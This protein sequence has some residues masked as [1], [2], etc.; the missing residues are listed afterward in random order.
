MNHIVSNVLG[1]I[2]TTFSE[3]YFAT[4][5]S[6]VRVP[7][8]VKTFTLLEAMK[9][10]CK[11]KPNSLTKKAARYDT[12]NKLMFTYVFLD[13]NHGAVTTQTTQPMRNC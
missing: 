10:V 13:P 8:K 5:H 7:G 6:H 2:L 3:I 1:K 9:F 11:K 4:S 12:I